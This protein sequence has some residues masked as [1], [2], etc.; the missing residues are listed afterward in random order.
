MKKQKQNRRLA[1]RV[2]AV[3]VMGILVYSW[4]FGPDFQVGGALAAQAAEEA[5]EPAPSRASQLAPAAAEP[6]PANQTV[7]A[8][9]ASEPAGVALPLLPPVT[10]PAAT[11]WRGVAG[12]EAWLREAPSLRAARVGELRPGQAVRVEAWVR[13]DLVQPDNPTWARLSDGSYVYSTLLR[14]QPLLAAPPRPSDAPTEGRWIDVNL[15]LQV[16]TAYDGAR[17]LRS[18]LVSTGQPGW[19]TP[20]GTFQILRRVAKETMDGSTLVGQGPNGAGASY[21]VENVRWTQYFT[22]DGAA[23]HENYWRNPATFGLPGSHGCIG[24]LPEDAAWFWEFA[25]TGTPLL[26]H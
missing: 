14:S 22:A 5:V 13:G 2:L 20:R 23:I 3:A 24:M 6:R 16:A 4:G 25:T 10:A 8:S 7:L 19:E 17:P 26:I 21:K 1:G 11:V 12:Q 18:V 15:T 9:R